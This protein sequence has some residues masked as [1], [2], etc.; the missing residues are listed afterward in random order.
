MISAGFMVAI[1]YLEWIRWVAIGSLRFNN[2]IVR[3]KSVDDQIGFDGL[4]NSAP[5]LDI[6]DDNNYVLVLLG[7]EIRDD[8]FQ[9]GAGL[10]AV[11]LPISAAKAFIP[12]T[13]RAYR[14]LEADAARAAVKLEQPV[15]A[16]VWEQW[17]ANRRAELRT[18]RSLLFCKALG[19]PT[20]TSYPALPETLESILRGDMQSPAAEKASRLKGS[21]TYAWALAFGIFGEA[22]GEE[23]KVDFSERLKVAALIKETERSYPP[24]KPQMLSPLVP[25]A[26]EMEAF[27]DSVG[28]ADFPLCLIALVLHYQHLLSTDRPVDLGALLEDLRQLAARGGD[29]HASIAAS[30]VAQAMENSAV[31]TLLYQS[32]P[33]HFP[34]L[35]PASAAYDLRIATKN[36]LDLK[37]NQ[38]FDSGKNQD[39][40]LDDKEVNLSSAD[41]DAIANDAA[42]DVKVSVPQA[43][44]LTESEATLDD[45]IKNS[46]T[47]NINTAIEDVSSSTPDKSDDTAQSVPEQLNNRAKSIIASEQSENTKKN[48][49]A[50]QSSPSTPE[51]AQADPRSL[52]ASDEKPKKDGSSR[53]ANEKSKRTSKKK[54]SE[55][56]A[57]EGG[58]QQGLDL[59]PSP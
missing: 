35:Q 4:M 32:A 37:I 22:V 57:S 52:R 24:N 10:G 46:G 12:L 27:L 14:L 48:N 55:K 42:S 33:D 54:K 16:P 41:K 43:N 26:V 15:F 29:R 51:V 31:T 30:F 11:H 45:S 8:S 49:A 28:Y 38:D 9:L 2:R 21:S 47:C 53:T 34:S 20:P 39:K 6:E 58:N 59:E 25:V 40:D 3:V 17:L 5:E 44:E 23:I 13:E 50:K 18:H 1:T 19:L 36:N 7:N 56:N